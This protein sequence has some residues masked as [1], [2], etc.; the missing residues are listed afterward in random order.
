M[1]ETQKDIAEA[2]EANDYDRLRDIATRLSMGDEPGDRQMAKRVQLAAAVVEA[3]KLGDELSA[4]DDEALGMWGDAGASGIVADAVE[5]CR[6][7]TG[8]IWPSGQ[9]VLVKWLFSKDEDEDDD[10]DDDGDDV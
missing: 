1:S 6:A 5:E 3:A 9:Y 8:T 4:E 10:S 2:I 7:A